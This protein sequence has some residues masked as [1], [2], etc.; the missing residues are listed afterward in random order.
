M[1]IKLFILLLCAACSYAKE[2]FIVPDALISQ[3]ENGNA[4]VAYFIA[5]T[6]FD[7]SDDFNADYDEAMI[8]L[9][10]AADMGYPHAMEDL[11][12]ELN[13]EA[14]EDEALIWMQRAANLGV[15][16][17]LELIASYHYHGKAGFEKN[18]QTAYQWYEKAE[19]KG[20][21]LA[22]NNHAWNLATSKD[23]HCRNPE[24]A[25]RIISELWSTFP[26]EKSIPF[27]IWDTKA[28]VLASVADFNAA[29]KLQ[30]WVIFEMN[31]RKLNLKNYQIHL[32]TYK[33]RKAW[34]EK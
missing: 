13:V 15:A 14:T 32:D 34:I 30:E 31:Q 4:E 9:R 21:E 8:W 29:I 33:L 16:S 11:A 2:D 20:V 24:K 6:L 19:K 25:L 7:G 22:F 17:V 1:N 27:Y 10:K 18:C 26:Y 3:V 23:K 28:A 12:Y 5:S